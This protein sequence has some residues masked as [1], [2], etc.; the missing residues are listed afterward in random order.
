MYIYKPHLSNCSRHPNYGILLSNTYSTHN[1]AITIILC[2][3]TIILYSNRLLSF[4]VWLDLKNFTNVLIF[5]V[6]IISLSLVMFYGK[7][8]ES[9]SSA[10]PKVQWS[11]FLAAAACVLQFC[12]GL[13]LTQ[14]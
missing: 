13:L 1:V 4:S 6:F 2:S 8:D 11:A 3:L 9:H 14:T 7:L 12:A 5:S 10:T